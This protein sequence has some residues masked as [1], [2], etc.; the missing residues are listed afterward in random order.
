M[1]EPSKSVTGHGRLRWWEDD[2]RFTDIAFRALL[3]VNLFILCVI[4]RIAFMR[5][6]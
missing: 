5:S 1:T 6:T 4:T 3:A 2:V